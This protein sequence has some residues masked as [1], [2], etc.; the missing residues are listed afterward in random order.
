MT[1]FEASELFSFLTK[2]ERTGTTSETASIQSREL[3]DKA[4]KK[5]NSVD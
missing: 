4:I 2:K 1:D 3:I 5:E